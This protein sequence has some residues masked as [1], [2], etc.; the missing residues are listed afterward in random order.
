MTEYRIF[1]ASVRWEL[2]HRCLLQL[3]TKLVAAHPV[4]A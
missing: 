3:Q 4:L 1:D 2:Y